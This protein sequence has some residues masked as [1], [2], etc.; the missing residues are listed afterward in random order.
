MIP[1][2]ARSPLAWLGGLLALYLLVP[3][4]GLLAR[5]AGSGTG[6]FHT[7]GLWQALAV[8]IET[9][10]I[11]TAL[12][13]VFGTPLAYVLSRQQGRLST[14]IGIA[15]QLPLALPPLMSGILL[16]YLVGPYTPIGEAFGGRLTDSL[17]GI[18]IA[19]TF[20][21]APFLVVSARSAFSAVD[22]SLLDASATLGHG[23]L[24]RFFRT[25]MPLAA[26]GILAGLMLS[27]LRAFGEFGATVI[28]AYHPYSLPVFTYVQFGSA[29]LPE[30]IAPTALAVLAA[31]AVLALAQVR[32]PR[33]ARS[34]APLPLPVPPQPRR[35]ALLYFS[36]DEHLGSFHLQLAHRSASSRLAILGPSGAGKTATL[37]CIAGLAGEG[38]SEVR[39]GAADVGGLPPERR[40]LGYVPQ[41]VT[42]FPHLSIWDQLLFGD[43]SRPEL[44]SYWLYELGLDGMED[45]RPAELSGGQRQKVALARA[46]SREPQVLLLDEPFSSLDAP[47]RDDLRRQLRLVLR[48]TGVA[49]VLVTHDPEEAALLADELVVIRQGRLLQSGPSR[50]VFEHP[51]SPEVARL[52]GIP[53]INRGLVE[54][55]G[56][57]SLG[58]DVSVEVADH[59]IPPG[60]PV[61][62]C[63]H[64]EHLEVDYPGRY[65]ATVIDSVDF[66]ARTELLVRLAHDATLTARLQDRSELHPGDRCG[67]ELSPEHVAV[68]AASGAAPEET[69][70]PRDKEGDAE[71]G[72]NGDT[73]G[74]GRRTCGFSQHG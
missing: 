10:S 42:L 68:W 71:V 20:V 37:R 9:A 70:P 67:L 30:T 15:V 5:L 40:G 57:V 50:E 35:P 31:V 48:R 73:R 23:Q 39:L 14:F 11:S 16:V 74:G 25:S 12:I 32:R 13:A 43:G 56:R 46:L 53:N 4:V 65:E 28:L 33:R 52:L 61:L 29:G 63:V 58:D 66:G 1:R 62:W 41:E 60:T 34:A 72:S 47:V 17:A 18:V 44:A 45:R 69:S 64:P 8:S 2:A 6:S 51:S 26:S 54:R 59:G 7:P 22:Q 21:A 55:P 38:S 3:L 27:W 49:T 36:I 24:S 19:Q